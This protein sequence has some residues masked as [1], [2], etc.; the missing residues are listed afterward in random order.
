MTEL[1][2]VGYLNNETATA[3]LCKIARFTSVEI[4]DEALGAYLMCHLR[5][6]CE[7]CGTP[8]TPQW[9]KGWHSEVLQHSVLLVQ[10]PAD[11]NLHFQVQRMWN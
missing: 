4:T 11:P 2:L 9:R 6:Y 5:Q 3:E 10:Y 8:D 7:G 1:S